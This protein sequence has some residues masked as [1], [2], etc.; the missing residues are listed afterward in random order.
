MQQAKKLSAT[1]VR[2]VVSVTDETETSKRKSAAGGKKQ[3]G[4]PKKRKLKKSVARA[5]PRKLKAKRI[6]ENDDLSDD[7][8]GHDLNDFPPGSETD[9]NETDKILLQ[10]CER[11]SLPTNWFCC[12]VPA[13]EKPCGGAICKEC[14]EERKKPLAFLRNINPDHILFKLSSCL[15]KLH[16]DQEFKK[17]TSG[18]KTTRYEYSG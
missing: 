15:C 13:R 18:K 9:N 14:K 7:D 16:F 11:H 3:S 12:F 17:A 1:P 5:T 4:K 10:T 8:C 6:R 2:K